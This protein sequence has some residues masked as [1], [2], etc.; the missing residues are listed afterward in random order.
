[1]SLPVPLIRNPKSP[2]IKTLVCQLAVMG[3]VPDLQPTKR[4]YA[5]P[6]TNPAAVKT[7]GFQYFFKS[8]IIFPYKNEGQKYIKKASL[9]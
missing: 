8:L 1:L 5:N 4:Q 2:P 7:S 6:T 3:Q 9:R